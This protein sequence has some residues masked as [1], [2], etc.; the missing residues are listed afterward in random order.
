LYDG[1]FKE[2]KKSIKGRIIK[3]NGHTIL[4][5]FK[6]DFPIEGTLKQLDGSEYSGEFN[7]E[8]E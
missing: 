5:T 7:K 8:G 1:S 3:T 4:A 6:N 2:N